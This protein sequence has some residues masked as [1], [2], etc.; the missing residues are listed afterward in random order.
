MKNKAN[1]YIEID[2]LR[3]LA[4]VGMI[5][6]HYYFVLVFLGVEDINLYQGWWLVLARS[7]QLTFLSLV[8]V[9]L[10][11]AKINSK[12][13]NPHSFIINRY[14]RAAQIF[15]GALLVT[16]VTY[17][18]LPDYF[19][20][21]GILHFITASI[22]LLAPLAGYRLAPILI[23]IFVI[24]LTP[25]INSFAS[26]A[27][28][29]IVLG[30][31]PV[32]F[33]SLDYFPIFPWISTVAIGIGVGSILYRE[34]SPFKFNDTVTKILSPVAF[35]GRNSLLLYLIH[36]PIILLILEIIT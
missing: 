15:L 18:F 21:F 31:E 8:G 29:L 10:S 12:S 28:S 17:F 34:K 6:F 23:G 13:K 5:V 4:I 20:R 27:L 25:F 22:L 14:K 35:L 2:F 1:R 11:V 32:G 36:V 3:G 24:L 7:V 30:F 16:L 26:S 19:I 9:S 33:A